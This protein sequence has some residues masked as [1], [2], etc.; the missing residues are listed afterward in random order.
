MKSIFALSF[1]KHYTE[2]FS[3]RHYTGFRK[4]GH[5]YRDKCNNHDHDNRLGNNRDNNVNIAH[6]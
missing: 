1:I 3:M 6:Q 2:Y 5:I 4:S